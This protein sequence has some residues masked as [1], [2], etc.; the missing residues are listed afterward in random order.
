MN[1]PIDR[2]RLLETADALQAQLGREF[3]M[4]SLYHEVGLPRH[5][6]RRHFPTKA[7]LL[8]AVAEIRNTRPCN[9]DADHVRAEHSTTPSYAGQAAFE[10]EFLAGTASDAF[11]AVEPAAE[12][13]ELSQAESPIA[14]AEDS[15]RFPEEH[16]GSAIPSYADAEDPEGKLSTDTESAGFDTAEPA[17]EQAGPSPESPPIA[18]AEDILWGP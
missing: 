17:A 10:G 12:Q 18:T 2:Q 16:P 8:N 3:S 15:L 14:T 9:Q 6:V 11:D 13:V 5:L 7:S 4:S 1:G